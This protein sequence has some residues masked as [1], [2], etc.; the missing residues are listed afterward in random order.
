MTARVE[1]VEADD[2]DDDPGGGGALLVQS[3]RRGQVGDVEPLL[4]EGAHVD[5][6]NPSTGA[7]RH[8]SWPPAT[9][10][11]KLWSCSSRKEQTSTPW[12]G[13][14]EE[15]GALHGAALRNHF[16]VAQLLLQ[17]RPAPTGGDHEGRTPLAD[18]ERKGHVRNGCAAAICRAAS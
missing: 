4:R 2:I 1:T 9:G 5:Q 15:R 16:A 7:T 6:P 18:S 12:A 17:H 13:V 8:S 11:F 14:A 10:T 3:A